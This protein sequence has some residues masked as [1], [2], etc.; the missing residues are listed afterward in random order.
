MMVLQKSVPDVLLPGKPPMNGERTSLDD[1]YHVAWSGGPEGA[2]KIAHDAG[3]LTDTDP[4]GR[5][6]GTA[7]R[8]QPTALWQTA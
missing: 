3:R 6:A 7:T 2:W 1:G 4:T 5:E 8:T